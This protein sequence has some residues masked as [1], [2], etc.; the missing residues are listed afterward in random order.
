MSLDVLTMG[1]GS[2]EFASIFVTGL[3]ESDTVTASN[4]S[5]T[6]TAVW[7]STESR[8]EITKI[9]DYGTWTVTAT[10]GEETITQ[11]VLVDAAIKFE[12]EMEVSA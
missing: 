2:G 12:I 7:N 8:H 4:G 3:S 11:D 6:K 1:G 9:K 10:D 5:K